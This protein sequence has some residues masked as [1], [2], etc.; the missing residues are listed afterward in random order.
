MTLRTRLSFALAAAATIATL[1]PVHAQQ[2]A[3]RPPLGFSAAGTDTTL[4]SQ[5][6]RDRRLVFTAL[7][8]VESRPEYF[9]SEDNTLVPKFSPNLL[10]LNFGPV[11]VGPDRPL[12]DDDPLRLPLGFGIGGSFRYISSRSDDDF[13]EL[14]GLDDIDGALE[15]GATVGYVWP[16]LEAFGQL[17]YGVTGHES[18]VGEVGA[19]YVTRPVDD[20]ALRIG[21]RLLFGS[22]GYTDT[23][24]GV[25]ADEAAASDFEEYDPDGGLVSAGVEVIATYRIGQRWWLEGRARWDQ[26]QDDAGDSPIVEQGAQDNGTVSIGVRRAF[27]LDF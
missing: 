14:D 1:A 22:D 8:G 5:G 7:L 25:D 4:S 24:F 18:W 3:A 19:Y 27:V 11:D 26:Y 10:A 16:S 23:Y 13:D 12:A 17:R 20:F 9:G 6:M 2:E 21:P 15:I